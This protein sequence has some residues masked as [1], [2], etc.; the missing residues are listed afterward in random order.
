VKPL[1]D[2]RRSASDRRRDRAALRDVLPAVV[3]LCV[4]QG[5]LI[6]LDP[7]GRSNAWNVMWSVLPVF[8]ALWLV[9]AQVRRVRRAD[10]FQRIIELESM[11]TAFGAALIALLVGG[12]LDAGGIGTARQSLQVAFIGSILVWLATLAIKT[13][14]AR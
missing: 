13:R 8:P 3:L 11:A 4:T 5:S 14:A 12:L 10:E 7:D 6:A 1:T 9:W 2:E